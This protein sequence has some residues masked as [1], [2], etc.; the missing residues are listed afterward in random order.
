MLDLIRQSLASFTAAER[1]IAEAILNSP[2]TVITW[3]ISDAARVAGVS[4]PSITRF[5]RRLNCEGFP[6]FRL[7][8]AQQ[9]AVDHKTAPRSY[10][11]GDPYTGIADEIF[12]RAITSIEETR[13]DLDMEVLKAAVSLL[14]GARR[15]DIYG[16]G[17]SGFLA[18]EAQHRL[19]S[20][21]IASVAY[22][23]PTLQ[24]ISAP[25]LTPEDGLLA[26]SFTG[27]TSYLIAN[28]E[29]ARAAGTRILAISPR[30][31][32]VA[33]LADVNINL[34]AYRQSAGRLVMP[35]G[36]APM[37]VVLD[38]LFELLARHLEEKA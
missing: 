13:R 26:L 3:S 11:I 31:S 20:L 28:L 4:E 34:N 12:A 7:K 22:S 27:G 5:C 35:T 8:L 15:V 24:M 18:G 9:I 25:R 38:V 23:D 33:S 2:T 32:V 10:E 21:G 29:I 37:Y 16:Y 19:A 17:G 30:G 6:D 36:R 14:A 1:R